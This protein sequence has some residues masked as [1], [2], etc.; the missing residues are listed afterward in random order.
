MFHHVQK[1]N[2]KFDWWRRDYLNE[3]GC[4]RIR[5]AQG[6]VI[7]V[8][9]GRSRRLPVS[10][11]QLTVFLWHSEEPENISHAVRHRWGADHR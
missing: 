4:Y 10:V 7:L 3:N 5:R 11:L 9:V 1:M 8:L 6:K 2:I